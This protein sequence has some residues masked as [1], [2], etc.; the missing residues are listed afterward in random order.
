[1]KRTLKKP[2]R[3]GIITFFVVYFVLSTISMITNANKIKELEL[4]NNQLISDMGSTN[5]RYITLEKKLN[6]YESRPDTYLLYS[7]KYNCT[8]YC[9]EKYAHTC[10]TGDGITAP[11]VPVIDGVT[12]AVD[13]KIIPYGTI[14]YIE[15]IGFR[16]AQDTGGNIKGN[17]ID[18]AVKTHEDALNF[19]KKNAVKVWI[20]REE[21][22]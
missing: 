11:G 4:Y 3:N 18:I 17:K 5:S 2:I 21:G 14:L 7:G 13:P 8:A 9:T 10:G 16:I 1:M 6:E 20:L 15:G 19:G 12:V 22:K